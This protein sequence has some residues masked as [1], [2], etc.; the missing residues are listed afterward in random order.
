MKTEQTKNFPF[1]K[2]ILRQFSN[3]KRKMKKQTMLVF[4]E[5]VDMEED[6]LFAF[7]I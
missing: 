5:V 4:S 3:Q 6:M 1:E 7:R 2:T